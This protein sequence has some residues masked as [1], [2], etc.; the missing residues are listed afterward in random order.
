MSN[1]KLT[2][3]L[4]ADCMALIPHNLEVLN[5]KFSKYDFIYLS[6]KIIWRHDIDTIC[7]VYQNFRIQYSIVF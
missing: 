2:T 3:N 4:I 6:K 7:F 1:Y 5:A